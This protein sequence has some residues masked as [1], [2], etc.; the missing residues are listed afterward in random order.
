MI[1]PDLVLSTPEL[2]NVMFDEHPFDEMISLLIDVDDDYN[3]GV[4]S[5]ITDEQYDLIRRKAE[6]IQPHHV[7]FTGVGSSVRGGKVKLPHPMGSLNQI[8]EGEIGDWLEDHKL[9]ESRFMITDKLDGISAMAI[10]PGNYKPFQIGYSRGDGTEGAD[11]TRHL[12]KITPESIDAPDSMA[13]RGEV[14]LSKPDFEYLQSKIM[15]SK[16]EPYKNARN[17]VAGLMNSKTVDPIVYEHLCFIAYEIVGVQMGKHE[18]LQTLAGMGFLTPYRTLWYG[19]ELKDNALVEYLTERKKKTEF[20]IDGIVIDVDDV[21]ERMTLNPSVNSL[22]PVYSFKYKVIDADN[23]AETTITKVEWR[24]SKHGYLKP[25]IHVA[26]VWLVGVTIVHANGLNAKFVSDNKLRVGSKVAVSRMGDVVPN[27]VRLLGHSDEISDTD[28]NSQL[29]NTFDAFGEWEWT[30]TYVDTKLT[31]KTGNKTITVKQLLDFFTKTDVAYLGEGNLNKLYDA[32]YEAPEDI[33]TASEAD[34]VNVIG[35][36][37]KKIYASLNQR[38]M[39][40]IPLYKLVG[41]HSTQRG[42]GVRKMRKIELALGQTFTN[43]PSVNAFE[44]VDDFDTKSAKAAVLAVNEFNQFYMKVCHLIELVSAESSNTSLAGI[45]I[46]FTGFR[47]K[48]LQA[49]VEAAGGTIQSGVSSKTDLVVTTNPSGTGG[50]LKKA[51]ELNKKIISVD[52]LRGML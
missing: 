4:E 51:R 3:N 11:I 1:V 18:M 9:R 52:D 8:F 16:G 35:E 42:I 2:I 19:K 34:L 12:S 47:D 49:E 10:Y 27:I 36:N 48:A 7:Y 28:Y 32:G 33:I 22:N 13:I 46:C 25:R 23:Y 31:S 40:G 15:T 14:I 17:M 21:Y 29:A 45:K 38:L 50:K 37:G 26:P 30:E 20:E 43:Q 6:L 24:L 44:S 41:A 5:K 39:G